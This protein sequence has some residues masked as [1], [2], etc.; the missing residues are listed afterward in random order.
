[1]L[2]G[3]MVHNMLSNRWPQVSH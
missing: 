2:L 1:M 3:L